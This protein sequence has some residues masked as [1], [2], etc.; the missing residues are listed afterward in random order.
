[1]SIVFKATIENKTTSVTTHFK[2][3][4]R[5]QRESAK[6]QL[7]QLLTCRSIN[8]RRAKIV[9]ANDFLWFFHRRRKRRVCT[10][11]TDNDKL[12]RIITI[13]LAQRRPPPRRIRSRT[14]VSYPESGSGLRVR[15]TSRQDKRL[16]QCGSQEAGLVKYD[17]YTC[18]KWA[19]GLGYN[20]NK[21]I[22]GD[23]SV[24]RYICV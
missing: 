16:L 22:N 2:E 4:N 13:A 21:K 14:W 20:K 19:V 11:G 6:R 18:K 3:I 15:M 5:E 7:A 1:M 12:Y 8:D 23:F 10:P 9:T 17:K 24:Q